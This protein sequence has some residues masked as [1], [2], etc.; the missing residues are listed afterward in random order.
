MR[1]EKKSI[2]NTNNNA[3]NQ[4]QICEHEKHAVNAFLNI[5]FTMRNFAYLGFLWSDFLRLPISFW[6]GNGHLARTLTAAP[7]E[8]NN[9]SF[10]A[11]HNDDNC[12]FPYSR[13]TISVFFLQLSVSLWV[14][15]TLNVLCMFPDCIPIA[16]LPISYPFEPYIPIRWMHLHARTDCNRISI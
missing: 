4:M 14:M 13:S 9:S 3:N 10:G 7:F 2:K 16:C 12:L 5:M 1:R 6:C 11:A 15:Y 8:M